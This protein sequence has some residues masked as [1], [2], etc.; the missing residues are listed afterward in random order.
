MLATRKYNKSYRFQRFWWSALVSLLFSLKNLHIWKLG[1]S[2][3]LDIGKH[4]TA[5]TENALRAIQNFHSDCIDCATFNYR[6]VIGHCHMHTNC[7]LPCFKLLFKLLNLD[8][9]LSIVIKYT[10]MTF[11]DQTKVPSISTLIKFDSRDYAFC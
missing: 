2:V 1:T 10:R 11:Y 9:K 7:S 5:H 6:V 8:F 4:L 3:P